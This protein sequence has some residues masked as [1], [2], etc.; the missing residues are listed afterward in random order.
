MKQNLNKNLDDEWGF[1][2][3]LG[4]TAVLLQSSASSSENSLNIFK[5]FK[6]DNECK[7]YLLLFQFFILTI[8]F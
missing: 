6:N 5:K 4:A 2:S 8:R 7:K 3:S 1:Q